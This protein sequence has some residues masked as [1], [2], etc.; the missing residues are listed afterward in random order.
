MNRKILIG[1]TVLIL[2]G[3]LL[4]V[5][6]VYSSGIWNLVVAEGQS[7]FQIEIQ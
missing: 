3:F 1:I 4:Q 2:I 6:G 7:A 5:F